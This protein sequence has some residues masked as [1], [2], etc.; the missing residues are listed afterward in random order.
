MRFHY[1]QPKDAFYIRFDENPYA[2]SQE[3]EVGI[4]FDYDRKGKIIG[5]E[6]LDAS[7]KL[8]SSFRSSLKRRELPLRIGAK[9]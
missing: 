4:I 8:A 2:E 3:V 5:I 1:D 7:K 6:I 9:V